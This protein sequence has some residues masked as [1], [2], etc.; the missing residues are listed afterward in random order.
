MKNFI[1][2]IDFS[3]ESLHGL[4]LALL[5]SQK[6]EINIQMVYVITSSSD[7]KPSLMKDEHAEAEERF[8]KTGKRIHT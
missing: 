8:C 4:D 7:I 2:P 5:F 1:I 6:K 3:P